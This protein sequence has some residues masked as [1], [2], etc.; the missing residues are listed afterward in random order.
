MKKAA[1]VLSGAGLSAESGVPTFRGTGGLWEGHAIVDVASQTGWNKDKGTVLRFYAERFVQYNACEPND[2]HKAIAKLQDCYD[3]YNITQNIDN[4]LEKAGCKV[5]DHIH[6]I[7]TRRKCEWH[8]DIT[9][10]DGDTQFS[11]DYKVEQSE[12]VKIGDMCPKCGG[13]MRPDVVWFGEAVHDNFNKIRELAKEVKYNDGVFICVGTSLEV[14]PAAFLVPFFSQVS[15]KYIV[16]IKPRKIA[17]Y[18]LLEG[19]AGT[20]LPRLVEELCS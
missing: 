2:G 17:D 5:V 19:P 12:P 7:M 4:F 16:D 15:K 14:S 13:Q 11:C 20:M 9:V 8:K 18:K 10:L 3:V 6:G 1:V